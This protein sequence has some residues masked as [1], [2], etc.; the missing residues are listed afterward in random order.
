MPVNVYIAFNP[1]I[2]SA[3]Y[4]FLKME[5]TIKFKTGHTYMYSFVP[6]QIYHGLSKSLTPARYYLDNIKG[7]RTYR[8]TKITQTT[9]K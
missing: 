5:L 9:K 3:S 8:S 7:N 2:E 6:A 4:D 1:S